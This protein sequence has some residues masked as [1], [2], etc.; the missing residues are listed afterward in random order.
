MLEF[1]ILVRIVFQQKLILFVVLL[2][3]FVNVVSIFLIII[4]IVCRLCRARIA[5]ALVVE[6]VDVVYAVVVA[7]GR[8]ARKDADSCRSECIFVEYRRVDDGGRYRRRGA[9]VQIRSPVFCFV[10]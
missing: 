9:L 6:A 5:I 3:L 10:I 1:E 8:L 7:D 2:Y 4:I